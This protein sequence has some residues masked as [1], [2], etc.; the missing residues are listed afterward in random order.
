V[1]TGAFLLYK[2]RPVPDCSAYENRSSDKKKD[3]LP[4]PSSRALDL[5]TDEP[6]GLLIARGATM[7]A[8]TAVAR[9]LLTV[10]NRV[11]ILDDEH[12]RNFLQTIRARPEG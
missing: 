12:R 1:R 6:T 9:A 8:G 11:E 10:L 3:R 7:A 2:H 4:E 5:L